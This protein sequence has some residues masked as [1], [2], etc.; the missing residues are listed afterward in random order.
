MARKSVE[1]FGG[2]C[3]AASMFL[4]EYLRSNFILKVFD[5]FQCFLA[6]ERNFLLWGVRLHS[7]YWQKVSGTTLFWKHSVYVARIANH[8]KN[9]YIRTE[10]LCFRNILRQKIKMENRRTFFRLYA[11]N[12]M[13]PLLPRISMS[14]GWKSAKLTPFLEEYPI[15]WIKFFRSEN[16]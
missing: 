2:C 6:F 14:R 12:D 7:T 8:R 1:N 5:C 15:F 13:S 3:K 4:R 16:L 10:E 11:K 9:V